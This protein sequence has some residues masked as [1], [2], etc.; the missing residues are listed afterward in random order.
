MLTFF[1]V[2]CHKWVN[3]SSLKLSVSF[4]ID[5]RVIVGTD[6]PRVNVG[7]MKRSTIASI[8]QI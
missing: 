5:D 6:L 3:S 4:V 8:P 1:V 7:D 2:L